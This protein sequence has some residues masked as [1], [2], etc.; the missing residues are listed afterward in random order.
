LALA[1]GG[2][3]VDQ[4]IDW[5]DSLDEQTVRFWTEYDKLEP[6][7]NEDEK[8]AYLCHLLDS[9]IA[10]I[11]NQNLSKEDWNKRYRPRSPDEFMPGGG[12]KK[13]RREKPAK[14]KLRQQLDEYAQW[15]QQSTS[16]TSG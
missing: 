15:L 3:A 12:D 7:K 4:P 13:A 6:V 2:E 1:R 9:I 14:G 8:Y 10:V 11:A 16:T 5:W